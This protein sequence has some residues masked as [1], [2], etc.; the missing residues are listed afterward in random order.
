MPHPAAPSVGS[1]SQLQWFI[2]CWLPSIWTKFP[3]TPFPVG[4]KLGLATIEIRGT[5]GSRSE[6]SAL[7][8]KG[9]VA[10]PMH[11]RWSSNLPPWRGQRW[12]P[13]L[14]SAHC[15]STLSFWVCVCS[16]WEKGIS[17]FYSMGFSS[18]SQVPVYPRFPSLRSCF[19]P[20]EPCWPRAMSGPAAEAMPSVDR[21]PP[22]QLP[23]QALLSDL[24][25]LLHLS[26]T[27]PPQPKR[28]PQLCKVWLLREIHYSMSFTSALL[29]CSQPDS[30]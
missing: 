1:L 10:A 16:S 26:P 9:S 22:H 20:S 5:F 23:S 11:C 6:T 8:V 25:L 17:C 28:L 24:S 15:I 12:T 4:F 3:G 2:L 30:R 21:R 14:P 29:P 7:H 19:S 18:S 27:R 13:I